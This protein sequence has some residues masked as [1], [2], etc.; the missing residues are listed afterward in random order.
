MN[1]RVLTQTKKLVSVDCIVPQQDGLIVGYFSG[2]AGVQ[3][4]MGQYPTHKAAI[5]VI[6][7][8]TIHFRADPQGIYT[9][10]DAGH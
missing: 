5:D 3:E 8:M 4:P 6:H 7:C 9:M 10:P 2:M 1:Y